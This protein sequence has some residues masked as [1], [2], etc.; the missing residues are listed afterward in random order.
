M[1][2]GIADGYSGVAPDM[3]SVIGGRIIRS[4]GDQT[5]V[6]V[7]SLPLWVANAISSTWI[8]IPTANRLIDLNPTNNPAV[9]PNYGLPGSAGLPNWYP[10]GIRQATIIYAWCGGAY[11][12]QGDVFW[13][14]LGGWA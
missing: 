9:N 7:G 4:V 12:E 8:Q 1:I 6:A 13:N 2:A 11:D 10:N 5:G 3:G 14:G